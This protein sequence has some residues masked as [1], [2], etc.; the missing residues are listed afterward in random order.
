M[1][2]PGNL[3]RKYFLLYP[4]K[5]VTNGHEICYINTWNFEFLTL[6]NLL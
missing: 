4:D 5:I 3:K 2:I 1:R 6:K